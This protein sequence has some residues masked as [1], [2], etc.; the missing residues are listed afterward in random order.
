MLATL[1]KPCFEDSVESKLVN[2]RFISSGVEDKN[3]VN[4]GLDVGRCRSS[5]V[6]IKVIMTQ[7][8]LGG[9]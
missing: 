6:P 1:A 4:V 2:G 3:L 9:R 7:H 5:L 8:D